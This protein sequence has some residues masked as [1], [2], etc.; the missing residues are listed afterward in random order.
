MATRWAVASGAA[1]AAALA[2]VGA[3]GHHVAIHWPVV[4][5]AALAAA[6]A[7]LAALRAAGEWCVATRWAVASGAV[8]AEGHHVAIHWAVAVRDTLAALRR[9]SMATHQTAVAVRNALAALEPAEEQRLA[10]H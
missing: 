1:L 4:P 9:Q 10:T 2:A 8:G 3:E 7:A 5:G 6:F